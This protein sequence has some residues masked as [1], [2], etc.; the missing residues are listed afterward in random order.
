LKE[1]LER[2]YGM[3]GHT[4][5][6]PDVIFHE[7]QTCSLEVYIHIFL[8]FYV[9]VFAY[10]CIHVRRYIFPFITLYAYVHIYIYICIYLHT[11]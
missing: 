9:H 11:I 7:V 10:I 1:A 8:C 2:Q 4:P 3:N 5:M 6:D